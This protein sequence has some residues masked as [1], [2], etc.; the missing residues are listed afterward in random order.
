MRCQ[1]KKLGTIVR[2]DG[3]V[4]H[5]LIERRWNYLDNEWDYFLIKID[6]FENRTI[7]KLPRDIGKMWWEEE[8]ND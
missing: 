2:Q 4:L 8:N 1:A 5:S 7:Q 3:A 6:E